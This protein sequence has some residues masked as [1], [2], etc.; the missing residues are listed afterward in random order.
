MHVR[1]DVD[2]VYKQLITVLSHSSIDSILFDHVPD[3]LCSHLAMWFPQRV[4]VFPDILCRH[5]Y[6]P[7]LK[8]LHSGEQM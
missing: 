8:L 2:L 1:I 7:F 6:C 5:T 3:H 4:A